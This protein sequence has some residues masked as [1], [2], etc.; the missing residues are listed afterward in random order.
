MVEPTVILAADAITSLGASAEETWSQMMAGCCGIRPL[1]N[2]PLGR[3]AT[4]VAGEITPST[5]LGLH[6]G[7][8]CARAHLAYRL[9]LHAGQGALQ[10]L[11]VGEPPEMRQRTGLVLA[12]TKAEIGA[13]G[14]DGRACHGVALASRAGLH[15]NPFELA[16]AIAAE[17]ELGG[18]VYALSN[19]CASGLIALAQAARVIARGEADYVLVIGVDVL[20]DFVLAGF[21]SLK[22]LSP[23][24]CRPFDVS[25][26]GL[27]LGEGAGA[28]LVGRKAEQGQ[29]VL[30]TLRGWGISNDAHHL[31]A[32]SRTGEGVKR[33]MERALEMARLDAE[34][35]QYVN[36]HG[37][38]T[39]YN[40]EM[41]ALAIHALFGDRVPATSMKGY[42]GHTSGAAGVIETVLSL[43]AMRERTIPA[44]MGL[45][46]L[47]VS[48]P[49]Q[50]PQHHVRLSELRNVLVVK[51]GFG[52]VN[53]AVVLGE[54]GASEA[55]ASEAHASEAH[56]IC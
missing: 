49:I 40:D 19:A 33:A 44:C 56:A 51:C 38:G 8:E 53:A 1:T 16:R 41:E 39:V 3:Y 54:E 48:V 26:D 2:F 17:L 36:A 12:S 22:A 52:G 13:L 50:V 32:P 4:D 55:H 11:S 29:R 30:A 6:G 20:S 24:P 21:S 46:Q 9:A 43:V 27:S 5:E 42:F 25:R 47:G 23:R 45:S 14:A 15:Y 37:T 18:P 28:V 10:K 7:G 31:T 35:V 34:E